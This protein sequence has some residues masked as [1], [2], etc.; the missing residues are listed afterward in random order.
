MNSDRI[1]VIAILIL[2]AALLS[3][4]ALAK[5]E[6]CTGVSQKCTKDVL[7]DKSIGGTIYSC[8]DCKQALC[9][10]GGTGGLAGT[11]TSS[12]CTEKATVFIPIDDDD[13]A[14]NAPTEL[15]PVPDELDPDE[16]LDQV[17][18]PGDFTSELI[19]VRNEECAASNARLCANNGATCGLVHDRSGKAKEVCRWDSENTA[20]SCKSTGGIWTT[21]KS[22]YAGNHP[23]AVASGRAGAC[24]TEVNNILAKLTDSLAVTGKYQIFEPGKTQEPARPPSGKGTGLVAPSNLAA[25]NITNSTLTLTWTDNSDNE[26]GVEVYRVDPVAARRDGESWEFI[27]LFEERVDSRVKGTGSRSD[28]DYDLSPDTNYCYRL[29]AYVGFD[30]SQ[31]SDFSENVCI[32]TKP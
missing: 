13:L 5:P 21:A 2:G 16:E 32:K 6:A 10:D 7:Y 11:K 19:I 20:A 14:N 30:R 17:F 31:V 8:Y 23:D 15:A 12:V 22:R 25:S 4:E 26:H 27:G 28:E 1:A 3:T 9:K 18:E 24:I 29:R